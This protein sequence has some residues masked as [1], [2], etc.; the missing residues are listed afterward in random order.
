MKKMRFTK[1]K[2]GYQGYCDNKLVCFIGK[3]KCSSQ[4]NMAIYREIKGF[5]RYR[6]DTLQD[7]KE[8]LNTVV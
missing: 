7:A 5:P 2:Y 1:N 8:Y 4:W 6:F 3:S